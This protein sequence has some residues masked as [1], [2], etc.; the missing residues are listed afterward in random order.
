MLIGAPLQAGKPVTLVGT[1]SRKHSFVCMDD[2]ASFAL[3]SINNPDALNQ[4]IA[5]GGPEPLSYI[6][7]LAIFERVMGRE[8]PVRLASAGEPIPGVPEAVAPVAAAQDTYDSPIE[9]TA[10]ARKYGV[11]LTPAESA[12]RRMLAGAPE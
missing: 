9:M 3:A 11:D 6:D 1:G 2:V 5:I 10:T 12:V 7:A 8:I 4:Y